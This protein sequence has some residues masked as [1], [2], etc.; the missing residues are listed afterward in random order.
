MLKLIEQVAQKRNSQVTR[1][2]APLKGALGTLGVPQNPPRE[3]AVKR[4]LYQ[5]RTEELLTFFALE[6]NSEGL[7]KVL[8]QGTDRAAKLARKVL[9]R[10]TSLAGENARQG[11]WF[12]N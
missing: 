4:G 12:R 6:G 10:Q 1:D 9:L 8:K 7:S 3:N 5:G 2:P 11:L